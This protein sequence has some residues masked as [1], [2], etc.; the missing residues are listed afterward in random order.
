MKTA[1]IAI[2]VGLACGASTLT[3]APN[4]LV[5]AQ[6]RNE[7]IPEALARVMDAVAVALDRELV[8][9]KA[10]TRVVADYLSTGEAARR[11]GVH[12]KTVLRWAQAGRIASVGVGSRTKIP[13]SAVDDAVK[14]TARKRGPK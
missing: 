12:P 13:A 10:R 1:P 4:G 14:P 2:T 11:L 6:R 5:M 9:P 7:A 8:G 3:F